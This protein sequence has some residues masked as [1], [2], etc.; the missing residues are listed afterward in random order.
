MYKPRRTDKIEY[1]ADAIRFVETIQCCNCI[2]QEPDGPMCSEAALNILIEE[3][4][5]F[6]DE[7]GGMPVCNRQRY[8]NG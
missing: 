8:N 3:P 6:M 2:F 5:D 7:I 1:A 4:V